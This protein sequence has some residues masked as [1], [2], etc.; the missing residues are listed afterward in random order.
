MIINLHTGESEWIAP[1]Y[2]EQARVAVVTGFPRALSLP[3]LAMA[4]MSKI[5]G[6]GGF[7][8]GTVTMEYT[9]II[10]LVISAIVMI[11][12][13]TFTQ[14]TRLGRAMRCVCCVRPCPVT[15]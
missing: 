9:T 14:R 7:K 15:G 5:F 4:T 11:V 1:V 6:A 10:T 8:L 12:L 13:F 2:T 3:P